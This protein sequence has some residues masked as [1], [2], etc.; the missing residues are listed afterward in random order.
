MMIINAYKAKMLQNPDY[1]MV[2][3]KKILSIDLGIGQSTIYNTIL[4]YR[5][6]K[7]VCSPNKTK[8]RKTIFEKIDEFDKYAIRRLVHQ[9]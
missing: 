5:R 1:K 8:I 3:L 7:T 6:T 9:F 2:H 4:Q